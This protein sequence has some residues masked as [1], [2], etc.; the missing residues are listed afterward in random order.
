[1]EDLL[2]FSPEAEEVRK[3]RREV[4]EEEV[5]SEEEVELDGEEEEGES[6]DEDNLLEQA[7]VRQ[8]EELI[9]LHKQ[10][11]RDKKCTFE[12]EEREE[13]SFDRDKAHIT[14]K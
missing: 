2:D 1:M 5:E 14:L 11:R 4:E 7:G 6:D 12:A 8:K 13:E 3:F 10:G 9:Y